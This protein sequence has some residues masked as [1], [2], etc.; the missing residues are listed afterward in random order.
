MSSLTHPAARNTA[1]F[2]VLRFLANA[3]GYVGA[4]RLMPLFP[5]RNFRNIYTI[6][7]RL[8]KW[9]LVTRRVG[10]LGL[11]WSITSKGRERLSYYIRQGVRVAG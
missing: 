10:P 1:K 8:V 6:M 9:E 3:G 5:I 4:N 7:A 2:K 11:E